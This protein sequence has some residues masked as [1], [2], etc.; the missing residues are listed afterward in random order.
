MTLEQ[1][2]SIGDFLGG[3]AVGITLFS[4]TKDGRI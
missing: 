1:L 3:V 2:G 4:E